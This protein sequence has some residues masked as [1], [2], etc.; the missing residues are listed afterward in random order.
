MQSRLKRDTAERWPKRAGTDARK[1]HGVSGGHIQVPVVWPGGRGGLRPRSDW[2]PH[3]YARAAQLSPEVHGT[4][5]H[6]AG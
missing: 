5:L 1:G 2:V 3:L 4:W 6:H